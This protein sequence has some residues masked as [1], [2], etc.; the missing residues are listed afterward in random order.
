MPG[1]VGGFG[2]YLLPIHCGS[3][4]MAFP[5]L[6]N[7]SFWLLPPSLILL[8]MSSLVENG[9]GT[10]WTV[11]DKL[12]RIINLYVKLHNLL[13]TTRCGKLLNMK[14]NTQI[15]TRESYL[16][17]V[18]MSLTWGQSA[19]ALSKVALPAKLI[20]VLLG[21]GYNCYNHLVKIS[22]IFN[23][24]QNELAATSM[25]VPSET[26]RSTFTSGKV[27]NS[28]DFYKWL[29]GLTDGDGTFYF[30]KTKKGV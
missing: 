24:K 3:P 19:W 9:A 16:N 29:V 1:L 10:G 13:N 7:I 26:T 18:K 14:M 25:K 17:D 23:I 4:D 22:S 5:R 6:N 21:L 11:N 28:T 27:K 20:Q 30:A 2:N 12:S 8:L 15:L